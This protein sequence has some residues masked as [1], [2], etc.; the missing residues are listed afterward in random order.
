[1]IYTNGDYLT[2]DYVT[3]LAAA[4]LDYCHVSIHLKQGDR[5]TEAYVLNR[6]AEVG[7]SDGATSAVRSDRAGQPYHRAVRHASSDDGDAGAE[8][9]QARE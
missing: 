5:Y 1:M 7:A 3:D 4:G 8:L 9:C 2:P 6:I